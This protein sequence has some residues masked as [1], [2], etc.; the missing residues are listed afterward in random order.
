[1]KSADGKSKPK[2]ASQEERLQKWKG[3][4]KIL[5]GDH[6]EITNKPN[7]KRLLKT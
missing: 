5:L 2:A 4:F 1:M 3:L 6:L 7:E